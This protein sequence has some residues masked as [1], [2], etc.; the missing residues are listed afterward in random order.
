MRELQS[1]LGLKV[2]RKKMIKKVLMERGVSDSGFVFFILV[3]CVSIAA[4]LQLNSDRLFSSIFK[5]SFDPNLA[6]QEARIENSQRVR[7]L[8]IV[9]VLAF[10]SISLFL[11]AVL[12]KVFLITEAHSSIFLKVLGGF[13]I[14][15]LLKRFVFW[16]LPISLKWTPSYACLV[17]TIRCSF[18]PSDYYFY[19]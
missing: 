5:A 7:N 3:V 6:S 16:L 12:S 15:I 19:P 9:K 1:D 17:T 14:F 10:L 13:T 2:N 8:F 11:P 18:H 4:Y